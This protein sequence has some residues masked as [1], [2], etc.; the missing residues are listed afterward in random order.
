MRILLIVGALILVGSAP[1]QADII[2][3]MTGCWETGHR[4]VRHGGVYS[5]LEYKKFGQP[6]KV[7]GEFLDNYGTR[8]GSDVGVRPEPGVRNGNAGKRR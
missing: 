2:C 7:K 1:S 8:T 4:I 3:K 5:G 6:V